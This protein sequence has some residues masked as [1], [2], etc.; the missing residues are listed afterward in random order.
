MEPREG[1]PRDAT[2]W[3]E[4]R[5]STP[6]SH[7]SK[8]SGQHFCTLDLHGGRNFVYSAEKQ[9]SQTA[10]TCVRRFGDQ[11]AETVEMLLEAEN[12]QS[13][14]FPNLGDESAPP[15]GPLGCRLVIWCGC[16]IQF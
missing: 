10:R 7:R 11:E 14:R 5:V 3:S 1:P 6:T 16:N 15:Q 9:R 13:G 8:G 4:Q 2:V 12:E